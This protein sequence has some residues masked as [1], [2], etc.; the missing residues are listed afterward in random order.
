VRSD[1][2]S[3]QSVAQDRIDWNVMHGADDVPREPARHV[4]AH[5]VLCRAKR[6]VRVSAL[7][8]GE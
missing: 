2:H 6:A 3:W 8:R 4:L 7:D 1:Q 5:M